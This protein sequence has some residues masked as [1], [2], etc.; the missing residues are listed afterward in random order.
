[1]VITSTCISKEDSYCFHQNVAFIA[2]NGHIK[3]VGYSQPYR[4]GDP[5]F[6]VSAGCVRVQ[7]QHYVILNNTNLGLCAD[8]CDWQDFFTNRGQYLGSTKG[9]KGLTSFS[10]KLV[11]DHFFSR[12]MAGDWVEQANGEIAVDIR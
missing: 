9:L 3:N 12:M 1:M 5:P 7:Q 11:S 2:K 10:R 8:V 4:L 6:I